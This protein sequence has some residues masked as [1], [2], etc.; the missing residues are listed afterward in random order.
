[1]VPLCGRLTTVGGVVVCAGMCVRVAVALLAV[2]AAAA[3]ALCYVGNDKINDAAGL[4]VERLTALEAG[5]NQT[6]ALASG[7]VRDRYLAA[8]RNGYLRYCMSGAGGQDQLHRAADRR[9]ASPAG[10]CDAAG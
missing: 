5:L 9:A 2:F 1:M 10:K 8:R 3:T 4:F 7:I 6:L